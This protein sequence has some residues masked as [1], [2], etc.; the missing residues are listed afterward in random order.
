MSKPLVNTTSCSGSQVNISSPSVSLSITN[1]QWTIKPIKV[2]LET[3]AENFMSTSLAHGYEYPS[4]LCMANRVLTF[5]RLALSSMNNMQQQLQHHDDSKENDNSGKGEGKEE[6]RQQVYCYYAIRNIKYPHLYLSINNNSSSGNKQQ[7]N[8]QQLIVKSFNDLSHKYSSNGNNNS[9]DYKSLLWYCDNY[10]MQYMGNRSKDNGNAGSEE[11]ELVLEAV[12][13]IL[14]PQQ[15][16]STTVSSQL[17]LL[18]PKKFYETTVTVTDEEYYANQQQQNQPVVH[19]NNNQPIKTIQKIVQIAS[20]QQQWSFDGSI[21]K[22]FKTGKVLTLSKK[23]Q[24]FQ[25]D[26]VQR[27]IGGDDEHQKW[28]LVPTTCSCINDIVLFMQSSAAIVSSSA[29]KNLKEK[30]SSSMLSALGSNGSSQVDSG[31]SEGSLDDDEY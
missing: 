18:Q 26:V 5:P 3:I 8:Q 11:E 31:T 24:E 9:N 16:S 28:Q 10:Y 4:I 29:G 2:G 6:C 30:N 12:G 25:L 1:Q 20:E 17:L 14:P 15:G 23:K 27:H 13:T 19:C 21:I 22:N 7:Q